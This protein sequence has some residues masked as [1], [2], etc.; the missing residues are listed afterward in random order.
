MNYYHRVFSQNDSTSVLNNM[1]VSHLAQLTDLLTVAPLPACS[2][3]CPAPGEAE[4][5]HHAACGRAVPCAGRRPTERPRPA[6]AL[7]AG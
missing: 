7:S 1:A 4:G 3:V 5:R 2:D 6:A